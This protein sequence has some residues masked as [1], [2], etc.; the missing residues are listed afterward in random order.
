MSL[1]LWIQVFYCAAAA[2]SSL[3]GRAARG[4]FLPFRVRFPFGLAARSQ[5]WEQDQ[6]EDGHA[7]M[8]AALVTAVR[9][10]PWVKA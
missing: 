8:M 1:P 9:C 7:H 3:G 5:V 6:G 2:Q 10:N 4:H